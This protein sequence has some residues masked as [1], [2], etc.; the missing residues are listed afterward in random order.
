MKRAVQ[1]CLLS[2]SL[3]LPLCGVALAQGN[4][5][6]ELADAYAK[7]EALRTYR[8]RITFKMEGMDLPDAEDLEGE[9]GQRLAAMLAPFKRGFVREN[10]GTSISRMVWSFPN[11]SPVGGD[12]TVETVEQGNRV[13]SRYDAP[14]M[15]A[16]GAAATAAAQARM[17]VD[18]A[19]TIARSLAGAAVNPFGAIADLV[20]AGM[21]AHSMA[22]AAS[23]KRDDDMGQ[24]VCRT[25]APA[26]PPAVQAPVRVERPGSLGGK[27]VR[28][29]RVSQPPGVTEFAPHIVSVDAR[30][31]LP[32]QVEVM[33]ED[34]GRV[35]TVVEF[36]DF[37]A[38]IALAFPRCDK[39]Q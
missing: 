4:P 27:P 8:E 17:A 13:A 36:Y 32:V 25:E 15:R 24:W 7:L 28:R 2:L 18:N 22:R 20:G 26:K 31:G 38:P 34:D 12:I 11:P 19:L 30:S 9:M 39:E 37:N 1:V 29:Y 33:D 35:V 21:Q 16:A 23:G 5:Q 3:S 10:V 6:K 14:K